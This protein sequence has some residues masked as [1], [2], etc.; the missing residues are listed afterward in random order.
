MSLLCVC[1]CVCV[2]SYKDQL[3]GLCGDY[4]GNSK[5]DFRKPDGSLTT[6]VNDFGNSWLT[7]PE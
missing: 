2:C 6:N 1:V 5:D 3:C 7:D 4:N